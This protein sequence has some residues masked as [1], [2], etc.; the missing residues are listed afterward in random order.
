MVQPQQAAAEI[1]LHAK[2]YTSI[3]KNKED[4]TLSMSVS[5]S[6]Q[7]MTLSAASACLELPFVY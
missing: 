6:V 7:L 3:Y 4:K 2:I 5:N 1:V